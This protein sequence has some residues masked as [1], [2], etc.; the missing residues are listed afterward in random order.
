MNV[1]P[2][3]KLFDT[4]GPCRTV[5]F[6]GLSKNAGK[7]VALVQVMRE[8][9]AAGKRIAVTSIGR[10]GE[11]FDAI[12][13]DFAKPLIGFE[14]GD[15]VIT[16]EGLLPAA[17]CT[18]LHRFR[19]RSALGKIVAARVEQPGVIEVAGPSTISGLRTVQAWALA[20]G[21]DMFLVDGALDRRAASLPDVSDGL[22][23]SS[24][25]AVAEHMPD[26]LLETRSVIDMLRLPS[27][28]AAPDQPS[29]VF[30]PVF[31]HEDDLR[32]ALRRHQ[33]QKV[34]IDVQGAV[35]ERLVDFLLHEGALRRT[36]LVVDCFAKNFISR[37]RWNDYRQRGLDISYRRSIPVLSVTVNPI[38]PTGTR[39]DPEDFLAS[40][41]STVCDIPVFD[42]LSTH[43]GLN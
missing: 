18:V 35:T 21:S 37:R 36:R 23:I 32:G 24:G 13:K 26:V 30:A 43:Y 22:V 40:M 42:V 41:R 25:A 38:S 6:C 39:F 29:I 4:I 1:E 10:D 3:R 17:G 12:Y 33:G 34:N 11:Q 19:I 5:Y 28:A 9:R 31:D 2:S 20:N 8:A 27:A 15:L 14:A 16:S 7:T